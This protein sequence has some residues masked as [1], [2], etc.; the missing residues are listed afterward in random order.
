MFSARTVVKQTST[1]PQRSTIPTTRPHT[2]EQRCRQCGISR[3][4]LDF[5]R[6]AGKRID[7]CRECELM[8]CAACA[9]MLPQHRFTPKDV[10]NHFNRQKVVCLECKERGCSA[11]RPELYP[12]AGPCNKLLGSAAFAPADLSRK[13]K[14]RRT[15][16][17]AAVATRTQPPESNSCGSS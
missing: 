4:L 9:A 17:C 11:R 3:D 2:H 5:R 6:S 10:N 8:P 15:A 1:S 14:T 13:K 16:W 7:V 12:C